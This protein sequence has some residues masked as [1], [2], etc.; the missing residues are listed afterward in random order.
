MHNTWQLVAEMAPYLLLGFALAGLLKLLVRQEW[1]QDWL[2][3]PGLSGAVK[4][5]LLGIPMPLCSCAVIPVAAS[6]HKAAHPKVPLHP[7]S[8]QPSNRNR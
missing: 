1:V 8:V 7:S 3:K 6:L 5:C 4:A 2:G